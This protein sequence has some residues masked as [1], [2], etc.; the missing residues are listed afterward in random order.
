MEILKDPL[1]NSIFS[2]IIIYI[3]IKIS[4]RGDPVLWAIL[5]SLPIGL[6]GLMAIKKRE[7]IQK[8]YIRSELFTNLTIIVMWITINILISYTDDTN[9]TILIGFLVWITMSI[10]FY[11]FASNYLKKIN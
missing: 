8:F 11:Y 3:L 10:I 5:S 4:N 6:F 7:N 1:Y 2:G 9:R